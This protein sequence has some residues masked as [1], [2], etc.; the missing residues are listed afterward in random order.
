M[1]LVELIVASTL[2][3]I[4]ST[5]LYGAGET[6]NSVLAEQDARA[7]AI[8]NAHVAR[9]R[10]LADADAAVSASCLGTDGF[11]FITSV[12]P[13]KV[14]EYRNDTEKLIRNMNIPGHDTENP[15]A[16]GL[17]DLTCTSLGTAG[18]E[19]NLGFGTS[20][21]PLDVYVMVAE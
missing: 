9:A 20:E 16:D 2:L 17:T 3:A 8:T 13:P 14:I 21:H 12:S 7:I 6:F 19:M 1:T 10:I 18:I 4:F 5:Y 11:S 15:V